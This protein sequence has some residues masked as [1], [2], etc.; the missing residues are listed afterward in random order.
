MDRFFKRK[1]SFRILV[2]LVLCGSILFNGF[3]SVKAAPVPLDIQIEASYDGKI[4]ESRKYP[5]K[6]TVNNPGA[7]VSG[8]LVVEINNQ[9][10]GQRNIAYAK[11]LDLPENSTKVVWMVLPGIS[12]NHNNNRVVFYEDSL[13]SGKKIPFTQNPLSVQT[14]VLP[15]EALRIGVLASD[16]DTLNFL[17][18]LNQSNY[19]VNVIPL[20]KESLPDDSLML[21]G[22]D[23]IAVN[24]FASDQLSEQQVEAIHTWVK[25]GGNLILSGGAS[26]PHSAEVFRDISP[27]EYQETVSLEKLSSLEIEAQ[28]ELSLALPFSVSKG[29]LI[30]GQTLISEQGIPLFAKR[31]VQQGTVLYAAYDLALNPLASWNGNRI[32][33]EQLLSEDLIPINMQGRNHYDNFWELS[34]ALDFFPELV[35]PALGLMVIFF[36]AYVFIVAPVLYFFLKKWD[37]REWAWVIIPVIAMISSVGIFTLGASDRTSTLAQ[38]LNI[39]ELGG[40]GEGIRTSYASV[41]VP[42]G[43]KYDIKLDP[44]QYASPLV[45]NQN[46]GGSVNDL[47][48]DFDQIMYLEGDRTRIQFRHVPY[49]SIRKIQIA[50]SQLQVLGKFEYDLNFNASGVSG[51]VTNL[52]GQ[53]MK[54]VTFILNQQFETIGDMKAEEKVSFQLSLNP[55]QGSHHN[56]NNMGHNLYPH[57]GNRDTFQQERALV[58]SMI[59]QRFNEGLGNVPL[60]IGLNKTKQA[61][62]SIND[63]RIEANQTNLWVQE[64]EL[65]FIKDGQIYIP[66]GI[67]TP[68]ISNNELSYLNSDPYN[69]MLEVG[70]GHFTFEYKLPQTAGVVYSKVTVT[71]VMN[72]DGLEIWNHELQEWILY[73]TLQDQGIDTSYIDGHT[74]RMKFTNQQDHMTFKYPEISVEGTVNP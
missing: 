64:I 74:I 57:T 44:D 6:F 26:Y 43:G 51:E 48:G 54:N 29:Q 24:D 63:K 45:N 19:Q 58:T 10:S 5:V 16:K 13:D 72:K 46:Y 33:W 73:Q 55:L 70:Q 15:Q 11:A 12:L 17:T 62:F 8:Q 3:S 27:I 66:A 36:L 34:N 31:S 50:D 71:S 25:Q 53:D 2:S 21:E 41:F 32:I 23:Y 4:K 59:N 56:Y 69:A 35:P 60:I 9:N 37:K 61:S 49:W 42:K 40:D 20:N 68:T 67:V 47:E 30:A 28:R 7:D 14:N 65:S 38:S 52:T 39:I 1:L 22:L 18:L